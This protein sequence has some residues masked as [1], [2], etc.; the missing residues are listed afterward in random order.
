MLF[1][2]NLLW[3]FII[4][5]FQNTHYFTTTRKPIIYHPWERYQQLKTHNQTFKKVSKLREKLLA[6]DDNKSFSIFEVLQNS[7]T[8]SG[9]E[10]DNY[11]CH[12]VF[13]MNILKPEYI[14]LPCNHRALSLVLCEKQQNHVDSHPTE[15][16]LQSD[17]YGDNV[18]KCTAT[19]MYILRQFVCDGYQD[20]LFSA[21]DENNCSCFFENKALFNSTFCY[22]YCNPINCKCPL[23]YKQL[24]M[25]GCVKYMDGQIPF[26]DGK[27]SKTIQCNQ[28]QENISVHLVNDLVPDCILGGDE[29]YVNSLNNSCRNTCKDCGTIPCS[30]SSH[31]CYKAAE[32]C[33]YLLDAETKVLSICR[34]G[35]H[36][37]NCS[38][39]ECPKNKFKCPHSYCLMYNN[40]CDGKWDCWNGFDEINCRN[41]VCSALFRCRFSSQCI[42]PLDVCNELSDCPHKDDEID[43]G[44]KH[45]INSC[46]CLG[47]AISCDQTH[48]PVHLRLLQTYSY[49]FI[50]KSRLSFLYA[51]NKLFHVIILILVTNNIKDLSS[52]FSLELQELMLLNISWNKVTHLMEWTGRQQINGLKILILSNN[53]L[54]DIAEFAFKQFQNLVELDISSNYISNLKAYSLSTLSFLKILIIYNNKIVSI[55]Q[56]LLLHTTLHFII[57]DSSQLCCF[58]KHNNDLICKSKQVFILPCSRLKKR[59]IFLTIVIWPVC[60]GIIL[61]NIISATT[62]WHASKLKNQLRKKAM[63]RESKHLYNTLV[64]LSNLSDTAVGVF[65]LLSAVNNRADGQFVKVEINHKT[66]VTFC[67]FLASFGLWAFLSSPLFNLFISAVRCMVISYP[68]KFLTFSVR[69][70]WKTISL[71]Y[72]VSFLCS[73]GALVSSNEHTPG[74]KKLF[75]FDQP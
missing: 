36:L 5:F 16:I 44:R 32:K 51:T 11:L 75:P 38:S 15:T 37:N 55:H 43:C 39:T 17:S 42:H 9:I 8:S 2:F 24:S 66:K 60:L 47:K 28:H 40:I 18:F 41:W 74:A 63:E 49:I 71:L 7:L 35:R 58:A 70:P 62:N 6:D 50:S 23:L 53:Y 65:F 64:S 31:Q 13:L 57:S 56:D 73:V 29:M 48:L 14:L 3:Q 30:T 19:G 25:G 68:F 33:Q 34:N 69:T 10:T 45:C 4:F 46:D 20:C 1:C 67:H 52:I 22:R 21:E 61:F 26:E 12:A 54:I 27:I 59:S 72:L